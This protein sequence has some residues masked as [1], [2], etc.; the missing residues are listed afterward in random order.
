MNKEEFQKFAENKMIFLDGAT[1]SNLIKAGMSSSDCPEKW[2]LS[3]QDIFI[4]LQKAYI[5]AGTD[6]LYAPTFT[7]N[8][9]K[10]KEYGLESESDS[11][12]KQLVGLT[13][14]AVERA[15]CNKKILIAGDMTMTGVQVKPVGNFDMEDLITV[16]KKQATSLYEAGVD[17]FI[18]ET[19]MSLQE[20]RAAVI[21]IKEVCELPIMVTFSFEKDGRTL[22][23]TDAAT[24]AV[25]LDK[26]GISAIGANCSTG[27]ANMVS[28]IKSI[29]EVTTLPIIAKPNAGLPTLNADGTTSY[30]MDVDTFMKEMRLLTEAG[31]TILGGCCGTTPDYIKALQ[32]EFCSFVPQRRIVNC[33][34]HYLSSENTL[35]TFTN[36]SPFYMIG[37]RINPTGKKKLQ[38]ELRCNRLDMV[39]QFAKEQEEQGA[40]V[41]DINVGMSGIDEQKKMEDV[42]DAVLIETNL[43]L[44]LDSS[45]VDVLEHALRRY[46]GR[47]LVNSV[48]LEKV[49][50]EKL[51]PIVKKYGA[52]FILLPLSDEGLPK[53]K[54]EKTAIIEEIVS[55]AKELGFEKSDIIVDGLVT[56]VAANPNAAIET[57]ETIA[58]CKKNDLA[59]VC[60]LSNISFGLPE[61]SNI[62]AAFLGLAIQNGLT[63]AIMN[64]SQNILVNSMLA[65]DLLLA[66]DGCDMRYIEYMNRMQENNTVTITPAK[67]ELSSM[68]KVKDYV[69]HGNK[70]GILEAVKNA[71]KEGNTPEDIL[72]NAL[73]PALN[74]VGALFEKGK[75]FLPQLIAGAETMKT[76]IE[77]LEPYMKTDESQGEKVAVVIATVEGDIHDIG[78]NLVALMLRNHGFRV[79]DL[80]KDVKKELII[81]TA[82]REGASIIALSA[83]MT[84]TMQK[85]REIVE[86]KNKVAPKIKVM[87][88]GAVITPE[89]AEEIHADG[90]SKDAAEAVIIARKI[91]ENE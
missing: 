27:P 32:K 12:N 62:N 38:E 59:T 54:Q 35:F 66:K 31:A 65:T 9:L 6:I 60:G 19:M 57:L 7:S 76:A 52:M 26:L 67:S 68:D 18:V 10:L 15:A 90:Y 50:I 70:N 81:E 47:A 37:E 42:L 43:P 73:M 33:E 89:Y 28:L 4:G 64:P 79:C 84:T 36:H 34:N 5:E 13:R 23:G 1:G 39:L 46:P 91:L 14:Q 3:H 78:K 80:G 29:T 44:S 61:R 45:N 8:E 82:I 41:L 58:Y 69:L 21:A 49:K 48:S 22:Y 75:Y 74:E 2:I 25:V 55:R 83:L 88:G 11:M 63:M 86:Y 51:L 53:S 85:M 87:I 17:L 16:Y 77:Y 56:T 40:S 24:A 71:Q 30:N 20:T 72:N